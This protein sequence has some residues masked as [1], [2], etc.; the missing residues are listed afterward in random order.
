MGR[1][2]K[3]VED[4]REN[5]RKERAKKK[6]ENDEVEEIEKS[7]EQIEKENTN[8]GHAPSGSDIFNCIASGKEN[9]AF[10]WG[11]FINIVGDSQSAK[12]LFVSEIVA[13]MRKKYGEELEWVYDDAEH[14]YMFDSEKIWGFKMIPDDQDGS[15]TLEDFQLN[16]TR[17]L[18]NLEP[19]KRLLY[20]LDSFDSLTSEDEIDFVDN[21]LTSYEK[22]KA[23]GKEEKTKGSYGTSKAKGGSSFFRALKKGIRKKQCILIIISQVREN[24]GAGMFAPKYYR[25][26]GKALDFYPMQVFWL[27]SA[28]KHYAGDK[29][30]GTSVKVVNTKNGIGAPYREGFFEIVFNYGVDNIMSNLIYLYDLRTP[31]GKLRDTA[32]KLKWDKQELSLRKLVR[33]IEKNNLEDELSKRVGEKWADGERKA[34]VVSDRKR[35]Y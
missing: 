3:K 35:K 14:R 29:W 13:S 25:T 23:T 12:T 27:A 26:G 24:L 15:D 33:Y 18:E 21:K 22:Q 34:D 4:E 32:T 7:V 28:E 1:P 17:R 5:R 11:S 2:R 30:I 31:Q 19:G 6:E 8:F 9:I 20:V 10:A 16:F